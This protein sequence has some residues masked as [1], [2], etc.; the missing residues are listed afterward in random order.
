MEVVNF[1]KLME[2][3]KKKKSPPQLLSQ[4]NKPKLF[5]VFGNQTFWLGF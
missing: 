3:K 5:L 1:F 4:M 2:V